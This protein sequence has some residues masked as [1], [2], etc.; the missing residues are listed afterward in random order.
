MSLR[1]WTAGIAVTGLA[2]YTL[3]LLPASGSQ[4]LEAVG[5]EPEAAQVDMP[6]A[7]LVP[8]NYVDPSEFEFLPDHGDFDS[9]FFET[10]SLVPFTPTS[11]NEP[12][13][14]RPI[15]STPVHLIH[16]HSFT[17]VFS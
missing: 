7:A 3:S 2:L 11:T 15:A 6:G 1:I 13:R 9:S 12:V 17:E 8:L 5:S 14:V 4:P 10:D 16:S